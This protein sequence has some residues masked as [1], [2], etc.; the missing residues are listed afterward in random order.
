MVAPQCPISGFRTY[1]I[2]AEQVQGMMNALMAE[3]S[4]DA[5]RVG[6]EWAIE[7]RAVFDLLSHPSVL[8]PNDPEFKT[9]E[10]V[11]ALVKEAGNRAAIVDLDTIAVPTA[12]GS[13]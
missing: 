4:I 5:D 1:N 7:H 10:L 6:F 12:A 11:C 3:F 13:R 2:L 8:Y 9:V